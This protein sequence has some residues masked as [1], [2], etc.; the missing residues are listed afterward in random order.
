MKVY[1]CPR[2]QRICSQKKMIKLQ[3]DNEQV[4]E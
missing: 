2:D 1:A 4:N 3:S